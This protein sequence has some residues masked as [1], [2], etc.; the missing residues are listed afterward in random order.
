[1]NIVLT[2]GGSG[3]HIA[4]VL[5]VAH[6]LK[7][8]SPKSR[9]IYIG[10]RGDALLDVV[11]QHAAV[12]EVRTVWAGKLRRYS[13]EGWRQLLDVKSQA[14]NVRDVF[15]TL[16]GLGQ[17]FR[18]L[19]QLQP[20]VVFSRGGFVS[21]PVALAAKLRGI[22]YITHDADSVPSL[23]NRIIARWASLHAVALPAKLYPY[24][25][26][27]IVEVGMPTGHNH[28]VVTPEL[29]RQYRKELGIARYDEVITVTGGGN[30][31]R[32]L[33]AAIAANARF[34]LAAFPS[35][36]ILHFSG[37][38]LEDETNAAYDGLEL[39]GARTRVRVHGFESDF[40]RYSGAA[41]IVVARGGMS[42]IAEFALQQKA[43]LLVPS[44]QLGWN[45]KNSHALAAQ[46]A[47]ME[48]S[49][50][51][52]EQPERL[53]RALAA[54]LEDPAERERLAREI[55]KLAHPQAASE[56]AALVLRTGQER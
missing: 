42:S 12:D 18:I 8:Q 7:K 27:K 22:P 4:P 2:G 23:A 33:N 25:K 17:S 47:V 19:K 53:G 21:V 9:I 49:E 10:Q 16:R 45:V 3:G 37:R 30:G 52:A 51:Q 46:R 50:E 38:E 34:L 29:Q 24:P 14:L 13:G 39:G 28:R 32:A 6:E 15:R 43:C 5:A 56:L 26:E 40:Y 11:K 35:L 54:L 20:A 31:A 41:D 1:M 44:K 55:G 36:V 48:L